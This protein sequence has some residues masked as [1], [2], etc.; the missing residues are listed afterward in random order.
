MG[1]MQDKVAFITGA[2]AGMGRAHALGCAAEG[3]AVVVSDRDAASAEAVADE[4]RG[5]GGRALALTQ[6]VRDEARWDECV[7][8]AVEAFGALHV[9]VNNAGV[10]LGRSLR[11]TTLE[12]WQRVMDVNATGVFLGCR[13]A[14]PAMEAAGGGSIVNISSAYGLV[15]GALAAA[16]CAS[17]GAVRLLTKAAAVDLSQLGI[18][19]NSVHPGMVETDMAQGLLPD[20]DL[21]RR[22]LRQQLQRRLAAPEEITAAVIFLASDES[23]FMTGSEVVVDGGWTAR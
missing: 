5:R 21:Q 2:G 20:E 10:S 22:F 11:E 13:A 17:K 1:R 9:L 15:G 4:V 23:S 19:V 8:A 18:R 6:D 3:A 16:Y 12:E 7:Q 14:V